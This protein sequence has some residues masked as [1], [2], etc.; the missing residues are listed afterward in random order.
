MLRDG[1]A[2]ILAPITY[3]DEFG[4]ASFYR[5]AS[6]DA[7]VAARLLDTLDEEY[8]ATARQ[9]DGPTI[10]AVLLAVVRNPDRLRAHG[11]V[12]GPGRCDE[13]IT[14]E[15]I[16]ARTDREYR[17]CNVYGEKLDDCQCEELYAWLCDEFDLDAQ[18][19][20]HELD[21][22]LGYGWGVDGYAGETWYRA[23]WD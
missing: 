2:D 11:Y 7:D 1:L 16:L 9:N 13:R 14:V 23:W 3:G 15:G 22:W 8:L 20:P 10:G 17:L 4:E 12:I 5:F 19:F 21:K 6:L 18:R